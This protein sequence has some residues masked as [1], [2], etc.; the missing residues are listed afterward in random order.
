MKSII[1]TL[2]NE[3][4]DKY[5]NFIRL[6]GEVS[7]ADKAMLL[8]NCLSLEEVLLN[9]Q[10]KFG[11]EYEVCLKHKVR[12]NDFVFSL[13]FPGKQ[14]NPLEGSSESD[15]YIL[16]SLDLAP[17]Y[18]Y[19]SGIN[20]V[21]FNIKVNSGRK[22]FCIIISA[23][24]LGI[25]IGFIGLAMPENIVAPC[26][27]VVQTISKTIFGLMQ[28]AAQPVIFLSVIFGILGSGTMNNFKEK[29]SVQLAKLLMAMASMLA[30]ATILSMLFFG[31]RVEFGTPDSSSFKDLIEILFSIAPNNIVAPFMNG[32]N[33]KVIILGIL[34]GSALLSLGSKVTLINQSIGQLK[35]ACSLIMV[36]IGKL[37][38]LLVVIILVDNIWSGTVS[39]EMLKLWKM[40]A[41]YFATIIPVFI[42]YVFRVSRKLKI[43]VKKILS[44]V[45]VPG[46]KGLVSASTI[47]C[48]SDMIEGS[49]DKLGIEEDKVNFGISLGLAFYQPIIIM[50]AVFV[51]YFVG[52]SGMTVNAVWMLTFLL[53]C[54]VISVATPPVSGSSVTLLAVLFT[55]LGITDPMIALAYPLFLLLD[56]VRTS[57]RVMTM[58][59]EVAKD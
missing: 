16:Q 8:K 58:M 40:V 45:A 13:D 55:S 24:L 37:I 54:F 51:L 59:L 42:Y 47:F 31:I 28:M 14:F 52:T 3:N 18:S 44:I 33:V 7:H 34:L 26:H 17:R 32:D 6:K 57:F 30:L 29:G 10:A 56:Y 19:N 11:A 12:L 23:V 27:L 49:K 20:R 39:V 35:D 43:P 21:S 9:C 2:T 53:S 46:L 41:V 22:D 38:P 15:N 36:W 4:I 1:F 50:N 25:I 5:V 48:F